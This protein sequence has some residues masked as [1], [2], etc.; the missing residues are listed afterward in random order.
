[1]P[2]TD[3][4]AVKLENRLKQLYQRTFDDI[5]KEID[6]Y[7]NGWDEVIKGKTVHHKGMYERKA[8]Q[9]DA[10][11]RGEYKIDLS[12]YTQKDA[13]LL[14]NMWWYEK[15]QNGTLTDEEVFDKWWAAQEAR[16]DH[17]IELRDQ[18]AEKL[19]HTKDDACDM[20][21][22]ALPKVYADASN[23][24]AIEARTAATRQGASGISFELTDEYTIRRLMKKPNAHLP[25]YLAQNQTKKDIRWNSSKLQNELI[26][27]LEKGESPYQIASR[28]QK[29]KNMSRA[30]AIRNARTTI[31]SARNA[32]KQDRWED[33]SKQG[34]EITKVWNDVHDDVPPERIEHWE[35]SGQEVPYDQPFEVGGEFLM[36]PGDI[37]LGASGW[38]VLNCR[39]QMKT[40]HYKF[41]SI[42]TD[43]QREKANIRVTR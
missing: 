3:R 4:D 21:N 2:R 11:M 19:T 10:Y 32:G 8:E 7:M 22:G 41:H 26:I 30:A 36:Y 29:V 31:T 17:W 33:L 39:C 5:D 40:G 25:F 13:P 14:P 38:N 42:L 24:I 27:G 35:A 16:L 18:V 9:F 12:K 1:M 43:E 20:I 6:H 34:V 37:S 28:F 15:Y 23:G